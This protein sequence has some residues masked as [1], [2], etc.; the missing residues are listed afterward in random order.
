MRNIRDPLITTQQ[1]RFSDE[2]L[3]TLKEVEGLALRYTRDFQ[4]S[5]DDE[6]GEFLQLSRFIAWLK[7]REKEEGGDE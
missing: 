6:L 2:R 3:Y 7:R 1:G 4:M 5:V